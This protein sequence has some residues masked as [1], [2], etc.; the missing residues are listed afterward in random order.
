M[1]YG[2]GPFD[3]VHTASTPEVADRLVTE[4]HVP[5]S[6]AVAYETMFAMSD[7]YFEARQCLAGVSGQNLM[8]LA[9]RLATTQ[10]DRPIAEKTSAEWVRTR[11][12]LSSEAENAAALAFIMDGALSFLPLNLDHK[13]FMDA[14]PCSTLDFALRLFVPRVEMGAWHLRER[15][16]VA[17]GGG[18][19]FSEGRIWDEKGVMVGSMTQSCILRPLAKDAKL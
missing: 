4:G 17:A 5:R 11:K 1:S 12:S 9:P 6:A 8:G 15:R 10:D 16:T 3:P 14:G 2:D 18:R 13:G 19:T 7:T